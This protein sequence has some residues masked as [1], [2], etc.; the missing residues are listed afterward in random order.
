MKKLVQVWKKATRIIGHLETK[1][2]E[3]QLKELI[4]LGMS[5][6]NLGEI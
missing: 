3:K 4:Y 2:Y 6:G 1:P 5:V